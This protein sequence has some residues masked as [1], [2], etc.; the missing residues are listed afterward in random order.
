MNDKL[1]EDIRLYKLAHPRLEQYKENDE[2]KT[3]RVEQPTRDIIEDLEEV[4]S[5]L[6]NFAV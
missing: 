1:I 2:I 5:K 6:M 4:V 3:R